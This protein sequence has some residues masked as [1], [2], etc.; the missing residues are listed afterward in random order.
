M[1]FSNVEDKIKALRH[2]VGAER[3]AE[4]NRER[5]ETIARLKA[6]MKEQD[7]KHFRELQQKDETIRMLTY[8]LEVANQRNMTY[9][10]DVYTPV[11][12]EALVDSRFNEKTDKRIK[13]EA[14]RLYF[15]NIDSLVKKEI[16]KYPDCRPETKEIIDT[17]VASKVDSVLYYRA[18]WPPSFKDYF[19][20]EA[21]KE[22]HRLKNSD[23]RV[24]VEQGVEEKLWELRNGALQRYIENY[25]T[26][27]L[28]PFLRNSLM[29][30]IVSLQK[31]FE[32]PC[33]KCGKVIIFQLT[34]DTLS[35]LVMGRPATI[36]CMYCK[37]FWGPT[38]FQLNL[39]HIFWA[40]TDGYRSTLTET[41]LMNVKKKEQSNS[42]KTETENSDEGAR[43]KSKTSN[44]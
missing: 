33:P 41:I 11:T 39:G 12:F 43:I 1:A 23:Y 6:D 2:I 29:Q 8:E 42:E 28:T 14:Q 15:A 35:G 20:V 26:K 13:R 10:D 19:S 5:D 17:Q 18:N 7:M 25:V 32:V 44:Y 22:A 34:N 27:S 4:A 38:T 9:K 31:V 30:Q 37:G 36:T 16:D 21:R 24:E 3:I 40:L